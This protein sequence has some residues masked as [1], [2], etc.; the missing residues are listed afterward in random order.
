VDLDAGRRYAVRG[1]DEARE[2]SGDGAAASPP[3]LAREILAGIAGAAIAAA[4]L[5]PIPL[6][7]LVATPLGPFVGGFVAGNMASPGLRGRAII[8]VL[9]GSGM[10]GVLGGAVALLLAFA[11]RSELPSWFPDS[12][13]LTGVVAA[14]WL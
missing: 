14:V 4:C 1:M 8:A 2:R 3:S 5:L 11:E 6:V 7:H 13:T 12:A 9:V 10:A